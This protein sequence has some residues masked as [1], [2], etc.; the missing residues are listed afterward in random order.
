MSFVNKVI[1]GKLIGFHLRGIFSSRNLFGFFAF[2]GLSLFIL[3]VIVYRG[4]H[5]SQAYSENLLAS[6]I[7][8]AL[9]LS[10]TILLYVLAREDYYYYEFTPEALVV[11]NI[12]K[13]NYH[14]ALDYYQIV[15]LTFHR[16]FG[17]GDEVVMT[18]YD[19]GVVKIKIYSSANFSDDD[20]IDFKNTLEELDIAIEDPSQK[21]F[22][23]T[24]GSMLKSFQ[25]NKA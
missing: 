15:K 19:K 11:R 5:D 16:A 9:F 21:F 2:A 3:V 17:S 18:F 13:K 6:F 12:L 14:Y 25:R 8:E 1:K 20:W 7:T 10:A 4:M 22:I 24:S 23:R